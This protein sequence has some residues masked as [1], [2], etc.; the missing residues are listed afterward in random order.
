MKKR[1]FDILIPQSFN[2][3]ARDD[4][5]SKGKKEISKLPSE[6]VCHFE[7]YGTQ[8]IIVEYLFENDFN[9]ISKSRLKKFI[10][11]YD[12]IIH[13]NCTIDNE[14]LLSIDNENPKVAFLILFDYKV[15]AYLIALQISLPGIVHFSEG[16]VIAPVKINGEL[17]PMIS[18]VREM[19]AFNQDEFKW[20]RLKVLDVNKTWLWLEP[21]FKDKISTNKIQRALF[22]FTWIHH[23]SLNDLTNELFYSLLGIEALYAKGNI[24][25][26]GQ[27][28]EKVQIVLG[29]LTDFKKVIKQMY[30]FRSRLVH[31]DLDIPNKMSADYD[32]VNIRKYDKELYKSSCLALAILISTFQW[33]IEKNCT[34]LKFETKLI[35]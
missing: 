25:I 19:F 18:L 2:R 24:N 28:N 3:Y 16:I 21:L 13:F 20:P 33:M 4:Q 1:K 15:T 9:K 11:P 34:E 12:L 14:L 23:D 32:I 26:M 35:I 30:D 6:F 29:E 10:K 27:I 22:G 8:K 5:E 31:G 17:T 7:H